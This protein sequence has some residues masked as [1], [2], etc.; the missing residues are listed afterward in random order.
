M[1]MAGG[2]LV[3]REDDNLSI[4]FKT[5]AARPLAF[6]QSMRSAT[7]VGLRA[8]TGFTFSRRASNF[9]LIELSIEIEAE[10]VIGEAYLFAHLQILGALFR[11]GEIVALNSVVKQRPQGSRAR[12]RDLGEA[13]QNRAR[14]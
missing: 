3:V 14:I 10:Q 11:R 6:I 8:A 1:A 12:I 2:G 7:S 4:H 13:F 5:S 9:F